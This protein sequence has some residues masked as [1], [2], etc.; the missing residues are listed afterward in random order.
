M[1][2]DERKAVIASRMSIAREQAGLTQAQVARLLEMHRPTVSE[3][4]AGRRS[5]TAHELVKFAETYNVDLD[6]LAGRDADGVDTVRDELTLAARNASQLNPADLEK[7]IKLL[8]SLRKTS[9]D[10]GKTN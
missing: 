8:T 4:E 1:T 7:V 9:P 5:V 6:W 3:I 10:H 2:E